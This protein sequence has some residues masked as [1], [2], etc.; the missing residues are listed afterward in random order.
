[1]APSVTYVLLYLFTQSSVV[2]SEVLTPPY[3]NLAENR[4]ITATATCG[5]AVPQEELYCKLIGANV[6]RDVKYNLIQGQVCDVCDPSNPSKWHPP[7]YAIDGSE[8]WWQSPPLSRG[9]QYNQVNLTVDLGQLFQ[10]AYVLIKMGNSPRPGVWVLERSVDNGATYSPWQYFADSPN[11]CEK[12]FGAES[13]RPI[14]KDDD[15]TCTTQFSKVVP[16]EGGE[17]VVSL[18]NER[19]SAK[20]F[21]NSTVL[22]EFTRATNVRLR[23]LRTKTLLGHLMSVARQDP[24]VT[25]RYFYS[26]KD[27]SIGGR[28]VCNGHAGVCDIADPNDP[29]KLQCRCQHN[30]CGAQCETCCPGYIQKK[31]RPSSYTDAFVCEPCNCHGHSEECIFDED[32]N[33][34]NKSLDIHGNYEGGGVCQRCRDNTEGINCEKCVA[35][36]YRPR[37]KR[38]SDIDACQPCQCYDAAHT[39]NCEDGTGRCECRIEFMPPYCDQ[40]NF[41]YYDYPLCKPCDCFR[42]GTRGGICEVGGGQCPCEENYKG[43]NCDQCRNTYYGFPECKACNC[44]SIGST[45]PICDTVT[46]QCNCVNNFGGQTCDQCE[47]GYFN[48]PQ[49]EFCKCDSSGTTEEICDKE[50]GRCL[51]K[52]GYSG[53]R[54]DNSAPGFWG[55]P[56]IRSCDCH[57]VGAVDKICDVDGYCRCFPGYSGP[58]CDQC[59]AG[60]YNFPVCDPCKCDRS[61]SNGDSCNEQGNC[62]CKHNFAGQQCQQCQEGYYIFPRCEECN[63]NP[64]GVIESFGGCGNAPEGSLCVCKPRVRGRICD[65]CEP[66]YWNLQP[67]NPD[68]CEEC[69]CNPAGTV[70]GLAVCSSEDGQ[71]VCKPRVTQRRCDACKDGSFNLMEDNLFGCLDC[72]CNLGGSLHPVC[73]KM[74]GNCQCRPRVMGQRCDKPIDLHYFPSFHHLKYEA[75]DGRTAHT[76][77]VRFGYD[78]SQF[79]GYSWRGYAIF[80]ELQLETIYDLVIERPSLYRLILAY[81]N[82]HDYPLQGKVV[83]T[84]VSS[85]SSQQDYFVLLPSAYYEATILTQNITTPCLLSSSDELCV[86]YG[87]PDVQHRF[88]Y[89]WGSSAYTVEDW[90]GR[91]EVVTTYD[92]EEAIGKLKSVPMAWLTEEQSEIHFSFRVLKK[93]P[94]IVLLN[95]FTP[96]GNSKTVSVAVEA[97]SGGA[98]GAQSGRAILYD[99][100]YSWVCRQVVMDFSGQVLQVMLDHTTITIVIKVEF[101]ANLSGKTAKWQPSYLDN[102]TTVVYLNGSDPMVDVAGK[103]RAA[104]DYVFLVHYYQPNL[105]GFTAQVLVQ[106]GKFYEGTLELEHCPS[107]AGCRAVV[108][109]SGSDTVFSILENFVFTLKV[110][111]HREV[112]AD[113]ALVVPATQYSSDLLHSLPR[114]NTA[115]FIEKCGKDN[116]QLRENITGFCRDATFALTVEFYGGALYCDCDYYGSYTIE[117]EEFGGAC[118]C[119]PNVIGRRCDRCKTGYFGFPNCQPC[120]CPSTALCNARNGDCICPPLVMGERCDQCVANTYGF[121]SIIGCE[122]CQC[123]PAGVRGGNLQC[124]LVTGQCDC[125]NNVVGRRCDKCRAG[126]WTYPRCQSCDCD[127]RGTESDICDQTDARCYCKSNVEGRTCDSC[128]L[129]SYNLQESDPDGCTRCFCFGKSSTCSPSKFFWDKLY[130][131][132][133]WSAVQLDLSGSALSA[134]PEYQELDQ[135]ARMVRLNTSGLLAPRRENAVYFAAPSRFL[136]NRVTSYGGLF[137]YSILHFPDSDAQ[138]TSVSPDEAAVLGDVVLQGNNLTALYYETSFVPSGVRTSVAFSLNERNFRSSS[139]SQITR[140]QFMMLLHKLTGVYIRA[141]Y[142]ESDVETRLSDVTMDIATTI[143]YQGAEPAYSVEKCLCPPNYQGTS[144]EECAPGY[145]RAQTGPFGGF[146]VQCQCNRHTDTCDP[147]TGVCLNCQHNTVG[148]HCELC[149]R[150]YHGDATGQTPNDCLLCACPI[151]ALSNNFADSCIVE[152]GRPPTCSCQ[153]GY[154]GQQCQQ[155]APGHYGNPRAI[156]SF[157]QECRCNGNIDPEDPYA[158]DDITGRCL[159]CLNHTA[160]DACEVCENSYYGDAIGRKDCRPCECNLCGTRTCDHR[161][162]V[163]GCHGNV[164]GE[165]CDECAPDHWGLDSCQGCQPCQ[166]GVAAVSSQCDLLTGDCLCQPGASGRYCDRCQPGFWNL[167]PRGCQDL[168]KI[169]NFFRMWVLV[170]GVGCRECPYCIH[171]LL[172][173]AG[174]LEAMIMP[175]INEFESAAHSFFLNQRLNVINE[176]AIELRP[177][178]DDINLSSDDIKPVADA[179]DGLGAQALVN[180]VKLALEN[181]KKSVDEGGMLKAEAQKVHDLVKNA[182]VLGQ[183]V[184]AEI[185]ALVI[186]LEIGTG[187]QLEQA[188]REGQLIVTQIES[189]N[190]EHPL[191]VADEERQMSLEELANVTLLS[192]PIV[193]LQDLVKAKAEL[194][195]DLTDRVSDIEDHIASSHERT[196]AAGTMNTNNREYGLASLNTKLGQTKGTDKEVKKAVEEGQSLVDEAEE[197]LK[198]ITRTF[199]D[200]NAE[201]GETRTQ[202]TL[203]QAAVQTLASQLEDSEFPAQ[204]A[205]EH[206]TQLLQRADQLD[207]LLSDTRQVSQ[208]ALEAANAY[209]NI[210]NA[211][212]DARRVAEQAENASTTAVELSNGVRDNAL[213]TFNK[214]ETIKQE[215]EMQVNQVEA[216]LKPQLQESIEL[217]QEVKDVN[218][219]VSDALDDINRGLQQLETESDQLNT[220]TET[221]KAEEARLKSDQALATIVQITNRQQDDAAVARKAFND[222]SEAKKSMDFGH[223]E[224]DRLE[225]D[226]PRIKDLAAEL[227]ETS[228]TVRQRSLDLSDRLAR[229]RTNI[230]KTRELTNKVRVGVDFQDDTTVEVFPPGDPSESSTSTKFSLY[231]RTEQ[232]TGLLLFMGTPVG[233]HKLMRRTKTDDFMALEVV[234][235]FARLTMDLG[236]GAE[237]IENSEVYIADGVWRKISVERTGMVVSLNV[238]YEDNAGDERVATVTRVMP[239][240][241]SVLNLSPK[242]SRVFV[243]GIPE[244]I[245]VANSIRSTS[246]R[247][248]V[249][250][251]KIND[252]TIGLWNFRNNGTNNVHGHGAPERNRLVDLVPPTGL[253]FSGSGYAAIHTRDENAFHFA[254]K[255]DISLKFKSFSDDGLLFVL[256]ES[257]SEFLAVSLV[258]GYVRLQLNLGT[259]MAQLNSRVRYNDGVWHRVEAARQ[260]RQAVLKVDGQVSQ[261][262]TPGTAE[263]LR[264]I[265]DTMYF[266]GY[267]AEHDLRFVTNTDFTGCI[268]E[269]VMSQLQFDLSKSK[270]TADTLPGCPNKVASLVSFEKSKP[271]YVRLGSSENVGVKL[272]MKFR[273]GE[274]D[275]TLFYTSSKDHSTYLMLSLK[276]GALLFESRPGGQIHTGAFNQYNDSE[277]HVVIA[278]RE[279]NELRL[280]IDDYDAYELGVAGQQVRFDGSVYFGG[281]P[282]SIAPPNAKSF[283]GCIADAT[284]N[285]QVMDFS[286]T[287]DRHNSLLQACDLHDHLESVFTFSPDESQEVTTPPEVYSERPRYD[288]DRGQVTPRVPDQRPGRGKA[289]PKQPQQRPEIDDEDNEDLDEYNYEDRPPYR[290]PI[291]SQCR[292]PVEPHHP[293]RPLE[294]YSM[295]DGARFGSKRDSRIE[296]LSLPYAIRGNFKFSFDFK[297]F[298]GNGMILYTSTISHTDFFAIYMKGGKIQ[299]GYNVGRSKKM[300]SSNSMF[301]DNEWHSAVIEREG[302]RTRILVDGAQEASQVDANSVSERF[303]EFT[304]PYYFGGVDP[305]IWELV[306]SNTEG[307]ELS[308]TGC[309]KSFRMNNQRV[310]DIDTM[311]SVSRCSDEVEPGVFFGVGKRSHIILRS[312]YT[313]GHQFQLSMDIKPRVNSAVLMSIHGRRDFILLQLHNGSLEFSVDNGAGIIKAAI[314][315]VDPYSFCDGN[316]HKVG[317]VKLKNLVVLTVDGISATNT[318]HIGSTSTDTRHPLFLGSQPRLGQ[319]RGQPVADMYVGCIK[320]VVLR[321][322]PINL[323]YSTFVGNVNAGSCPTD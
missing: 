210:V 131:M 280:D 138:A 308:F 277:W 91:H 102:T 269:I 296:Y 9:M 7:E 47:H 5:E 289:T 64:A 70:G 275:G 191:D 189:I 149:G 301:V 199:R 245:E 178:V 121:D 126:Y 73:D 110:P 150:G 321:E 168:L 263:F 132:T 148:D 95:Y 232:P 155:C 90:D 120:D 66:L 118:P 305:S 156:G 6:N 71:C 56:L 228:A 209:L 8:R 147:V 306:R 288:P 213:E 157:C 234:N 285:G 270:E 63:C 42:N 311:N 177:L 170:D 201:L 307:I 88:P 26:V 3:F 99:C 10:V 20:N 127:I 220:V 46:G 315:P 119:R 302:T 16:L 1:M 250:E 164:V 163:C 290:G 116:F 137:T 2:L 140:D 291:D 69:A 193:D 292:L 17:I 279:V 303:V 297:T 24:T 53:T 225:K 31:W 293:D 313:V 194:L 317:V 218:Q 49:C 139:G 14:V 84:P 256:R 165:Q 262:T 249:E 184:V 182:H 323:A 78:E 206:T 319:R 246:Y 259:G 34:N 260:G 312:R 45:S 13:L 248:Q 195:Q 287:D 48:H 36:F 230:E 254:D 135:L 72:G 237:S 27:I 187:A 322:E 314:A 143:Y 98:Q 283:S 180:N 185:N 144:C 300:L 68:G 304:A 276:Q 242:V 282:S 316:W 123:S 92:D 117:C 133:G 183:N 261:G 77:A 29:Y 192:Q 125:L 247:G 212:G 299:F 22:Q 82:P 158:C 141:H 219:H 83:T 107:E 239:G 76:E 104:G 252:H 160:G 21:F 129:G 94:H 197:N 130:Q 28:C 122:E 258:K 167:T 103:L 161:T 229:L 101:E 112:W 274:R 25:R 190:L 43:L 241:S 309:L 233:G 196:E 39:G 203:L 222:G 134:S 96:S 281:V 50:T 57:S 136:G 97:V 271:G 41:G 35:R 12:F 255:F 205:A 52:E 294:S 61:G 266:G 60:F 251:L 113:Y 33:I 231:T 85:T 19:P 272:V 216:E 67:Y 224:V 32:V 238:H 79:P 108:T 179:I 267:P 202:K 37:G 169:T 152:V 65:V 30:T 235:G 265:P 223:I 173:T 74:N 172:D 217:V 159:R 154:V 115:E 151:P 15:V 175:T 51:C 200:F 87:Y 166:C 240:R 100:A 124:D 188:L 4:R 23:L 286:S 81:R 226:I 221:R 142:H 59:R 227:T 298:D 264:S 236:S 153:P 162:G 75:E 38:E 111:S 204:V 114:D 208:N 146:C 214:S 106:N 174:E 145:Y 80:S 176:S 109:H 318:G 89:A 55:Y 40:C 268:D 244:G 198:N 310:D 295:E 257:P 186:G 207:D 86:H 273:S 243:G 253:R 278:A 11:D 18:L 215:A 105:P 320:N 128:V 93:G 58:K 62:Y 44:S 171:T 181:A 54:C 211:I 284:V